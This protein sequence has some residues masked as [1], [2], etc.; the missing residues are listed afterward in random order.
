MQII[1]GTSKNSLKKFYF[2][3]QYFRKLARK[4]KS[5]V[6]F[7]Q[8]C[9]FPLSY[10]NYKN[11]NESEQGIICWS[12]YVNDLKKTIITFREENLTKAVM[13]LVV[14]W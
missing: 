6:L 14:N 12:E 4:S 1:Q 10:R 5:K 8:Y 2:Y 9:V 13:L 3:F 7:W 11:F